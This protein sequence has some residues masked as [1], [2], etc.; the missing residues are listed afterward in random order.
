MTKEFC[1]WCGELKAEHGQAFC[2]DCIADFP[3]PIKDISEG[4]DNDFGVCHVCGNKLEYPPEDFG[5]LCLSCM[6]W[7]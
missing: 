5:N 2:A 4:P 3:E 6:W 7:I 1:A